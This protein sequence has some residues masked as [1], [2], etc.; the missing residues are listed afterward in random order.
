MLPKDALDRLNGARNLLQSYPR[1]WVAGK[2]CLDIGCG[3]GNMLLAATERGAREVVGVDI[4]LDDYGDN[5][6]VQLARDHRIDITRVGFVEGRTEDQHFPTGAF[7]FITMFDVI[8][9]VSNPAELIAEVFRI[10]RPGGI[11]ILD[12]S[13]LYYSPIGHHVW[14][15]YPRE[16]HP[17]AHLYKDFDR[18]NAQHR[19]DDWS[20]RHFSELNK[21]TRA[22]L[23]H[24]L[25]QA[26][27]TVVDKS[28]KRVGEQVFQQFAERINMS[29]VPSEE[30][31]FNEW[32]RRISTKQRAAA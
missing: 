22:Q 20:W 30:D 27:F 10:L 13:P 18:T 28:G 26:G 12:V 7:D 11:F 25:G 19:V 3:T 32:V 29:L 21:V 8:E 15:Y 24:Y 1:E 5:C 14:G 23:D 31:L 17:W 6:F 16:T 4:D 2:K 9:H